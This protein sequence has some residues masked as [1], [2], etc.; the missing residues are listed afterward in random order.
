MNKIL[1]LCRGVSGSG[2]SSLARI[3]ASTINGDIE[4]SLGNRRKT[5]LARCFETD[6]YFLDWQGQY[7]FN[8]NL[9]GSAHEWNARQIAR[10]YEVNRSW[11]NIYDLVAVVSNTF[12]TKKE[13]RQLLT[14]LQEL[15]TPPDT[16]RLV[17]PE[18]EWWQQRNVAELIKRNTH[19]V[20]PETIMKQ[21]ARWQ[22]L[23]QG[24]YCLADAIKLVAE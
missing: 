23:P 17:E 7:Q 5:G 1:T 16:I 3:I 10:F 21:L 22:P 15:G 4:D 6:N 20:P 2:K 11:N 12:T 13:I 18:T 24:E 9:L 14:R 8:A 19:G